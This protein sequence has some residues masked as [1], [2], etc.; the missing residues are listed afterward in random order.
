MFDAVTVVVKVF[1]NIVFQFMLNGL[2]LG[3]C[4][5]II[6]F[7]LGRLHEF[8]QDFLAHA[9]VFETAVEHML[10]EGFIVGIAKFEF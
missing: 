6:A 4:I 8:F 10:L 9:V 5:I 1:G 7:E 2:E 3:F